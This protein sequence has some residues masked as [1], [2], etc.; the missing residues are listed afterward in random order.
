MLI[1]KLGK[2]FLLFP[3]SAILSGTGSTNSAL[4]NPIRVTKKPIRASPKKTAQATSWL[5]V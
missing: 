3:G 4:Q 2:P 5:Q 1:T